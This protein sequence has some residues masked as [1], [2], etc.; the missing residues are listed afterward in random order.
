MPDWPHAPVHKIE[1][2][3]IYMVTAGTYRKVPLI[4][5]KDKLTVVRNMLFETALDFGWELQ[6]WAIL[7]NHYHFV[8]ISP[9]R[10]ASL[11]KFIRTLHSKTAIQLNRMDGTAGRRVWFQYWDSR[12]TFERSYL[13]R[14]NYVHLNPLHHGVA[15]RPKQYPW[16]SAAWFER[17]ADPAF[18]RT[19][20]SFEVD[21]VNVPDEF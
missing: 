15:E 14:L 9:K 1:R 21:R 12:I 5:S 4:G 19:V 17:T 10:A 13:A 7:A 11:R 18:Q 6:A 2:A 20:G 3:G 8:A 16:C